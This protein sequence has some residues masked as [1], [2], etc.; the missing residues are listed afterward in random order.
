MVTSSMTMSETQQESSARTCVAVHCE[1]CGRRF[2]A[3]KWREGIVCPQCRSGQVKPLVAPGGAVDYYVADRSK[4]YTPADIRFAQW[5]KWCELI[6]PRQFE[7]SLI[8]LNRQLQEGK[9]PRPV[10]EIM[11]EQGFLGE[12]EAVS[13]LEFLSLPRPDEQDQAFAEALQASVEVDRAGIARTQQLQRRA[14]RQCHEVPPLCQL[15]VDCRVLSE[16]QML[17]VLKLQERSGQGA[18]ATVRKMI[19]KALGREPARKVLKELSFRTPAVRA[20]VIMVALLVLGI[21]L[22]AWNASYGGTRMYV[23]CHRCGEVSQVRW[24]AT[25]PVTC[26]RCGKLA[27]RYA[28]VCRKCSSIFVRESP[29][30]HEPCPDC[31]CPHARSVTPEDLR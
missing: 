23:K 28:V 29:Y 13:L 16:A 19:E 1:N 31:G 18:L 9:P 2:R 24:S 20:A 4:G 12:R 17:A 7:L 21:G 14:A 22:W 8:K 26:R 27:A 30:S 15:L 3:R 6:T 5:A 10:H 25:F 11:M